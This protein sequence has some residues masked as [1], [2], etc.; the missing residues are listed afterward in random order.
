MNRSNEIYNQRINEVINY[1]NNN[2]DRSIPLDELASVA[3]FSPYHF[4]R[5]FVAVTGESVNN[6]TSRMRLEKAARLLK[7]SQEPIAA[8]AYKCG[9][10]STAT[11][12]RAF[13]QYFGLSPV[14]TEK[15]EK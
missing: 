13:K 6:F 12:S 14:Y 8:I 4:H 1:V 15:M 5:I 3:L 10:S 9:Y 11:L 2:L 7:F